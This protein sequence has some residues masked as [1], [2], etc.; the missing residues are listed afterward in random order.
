MQTYSPVSVLTGHASGLTEPRRIGCEVDGSTSGHAASQP[1]LRGHSIG[2]TYPIRVVGYG[3]N[4]WAVESPS[5][6]T[7][8]R[9]YGPGSCAMAHA[10]A[11]QLK[12]SHPDGHLY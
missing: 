11:R 1:G 4:S 6:E 8:A 10:K 9:Y 3:D 2:D 5:G 12:A 7:L